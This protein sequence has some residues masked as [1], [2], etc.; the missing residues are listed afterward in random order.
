MKK[1]K[2]AVALV[3]ALSSIAASTARAD[4]ITY[5]FSNTGIYN[6][7]Q[8]KDTSYFATATFTDVTQKVRSVTSVLY[9]DLVMTVMSGLSADVGAYVNDWAFNYAT[10]TTANLTA[11]WVN[12]VGNV[13]ATNV[14]TDGYKNFGGDKGGSFDLVFNFDTSNPGQL[15]LGKSSEYKLSGAGLTASSF[16]VKSSTDVYNA[17]V[18]VQG[19]ASPSSF[20]Y[21]IT[22]VPPNTPLPPAAIPEPTTVA[23]L[24]L[25][26][27]GFAAS[28]RKSTKK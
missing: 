10:T 12:Q 8:L 7:T 24:G 19:M 22:S 6:G 13:Q 15:G 23:L 3:L 16:T 9:V 11:D 27:L 1:A 21:G 4:V 5:Y 14:D 26:L 28:R 2:I 17:A 25:G 20:F 18:H